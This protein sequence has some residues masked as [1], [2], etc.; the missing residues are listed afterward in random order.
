[1]KA[2][3]KG[4]LEYQWWVAEDGSRAL[5]KETFDSSEALLQHF[6]NVGPSLP[7][8]LAIAPFTR[9]EVFGDVS[10]EARAALDGFNAVYFSHVVGF[11]R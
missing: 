9:L 5:L 11:T 10:A 6:A 4:M 1:M 2:G 7:E 8:L 3:E